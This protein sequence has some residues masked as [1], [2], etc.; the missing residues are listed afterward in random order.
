MAAPDLPAWA[1]GLSALVASAGAAFWLT[2]NERKKRKDDPAAVAPEAQV[3][4][5][6]FTERSLMERLIVALTKLEVAVERSADC[7]EEVAAQ[8][9]AEQ[10]RRE[11]AAEVEQALRRQ[12]MMDR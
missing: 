10:H 2:W 11:L 6:T 12:G 7:T 9:K 8:L 4:A 1:S 5:A 3:V